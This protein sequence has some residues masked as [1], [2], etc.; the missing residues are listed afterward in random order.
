[1]AVD[2][3]R[4]LKNLNEYLIKQ[5]IS[6]E[7]RGKVWEILKISIGEPETMW[8]T[9]FSVPVEVSIEFTDIDDLVEFLYNIEKRI[10]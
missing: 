10:I 2:E 5:D 9:F 3:K 7:T 1:M 6:W 4:V 8:D